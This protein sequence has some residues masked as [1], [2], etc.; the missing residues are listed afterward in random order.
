MQF[1]QKRDDIDI[2]EL[3]RNRRQKPSETFDSF[4]DSVNI[5][6]DQLEIPWS[7][8]KLVRVLKNN[9]RPEI[10]HELLNV[11]ISTVSELRENVKRAHG[12]SKSSPFRR[13]ISE[14]ILESEYQK[15]SE[16]ENEL[17]VDAF[18]LKCWNCRKDGHIYQDCLADYGCGAD[19]TYKSNCAKC[20]K[21]S[22]SG[23]SKLPYKPKT[24]SAFRNQS[25]MTD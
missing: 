14:L 24:S 25:T 9:L 4:Y 18:T 2:E 12:Y 22:K 3:I 7:S 1:R 16:S 17:E 20:A 13:E 23:A 15:G 10:R 19:N 5:L 11:D 6:V 8:R 21:N